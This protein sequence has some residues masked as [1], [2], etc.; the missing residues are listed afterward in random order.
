MAHYREGK[1]TKKLSLATKTFIGF[2][3]GTEYEAQE[4]PSVID[5]LINM[6]PSNVFKAFTEGNMLQIIVF[7][8]F[9][10]VAFIMLGEKGKRMTESVQNFADAMYKITAIVMEFS[11]NGGIS[12]KNPAEEICKEHL[13]GMGGYRK[14]NE[15]QR[16]HSGFVGA[17]LRLTSAWSND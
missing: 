12:C 13:E 6:F 11:P 4:M 10:G 5:T 8:I 1:K 16:I 15:Q 17:V 2:F 3:A 14:H 7:A 9:L